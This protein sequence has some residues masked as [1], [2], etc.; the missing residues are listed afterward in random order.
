MKTN[1]SL[2]FA[3]D[4]FGESDSSPDMDAVF[5]RNLIGGFSA[6]QENYPLYQGG[7]INPF[8]PYHLSY[9]LTLFR[10]MWLHTFPTDPRGEAM[11]EH[12]RKILLDQDGITPTVSDF[13]L[14]IS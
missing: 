12:H 10:H 2:L 1:L 11:Q 5:K 3:D 9:K 7:F 13:G 6:N 4:T 14:Y 8:K